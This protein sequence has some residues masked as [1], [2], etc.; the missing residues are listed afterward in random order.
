VPTSPALTGVGSP[1]LAPTSVPLSQ[2]QAERAKA[3]RRPVIHKLALGPASEA[4]LLNDKPDGLTEQEFKSALDKV[5]DLENGK[6]VLK[7]KAFKELD[8]FSYRA[9]S[10]ADRQAAIENA[11]RAYDKLRLNAAEPEWEKLLPPEERGTGKC[12]SKLQAK[13]AGG[14]IQLVKA[15]KINVHRAE[16]SGRDTP[17]NTEGDNVS[18]D[19]PSSTS[20]KGSESMTRSYSNPGATKSRRVSEKE[21]QTKR[22]LAKPGSK[23]AKSAGTK[24]S[25]KKLLGKESTKIKSSEFV[26]GSDDEDDNNIIPSLAA[27]V[28]PL[29]AKPTSKPAVKRAREDASDQTL[30]PVTKK[31]RASSNTSPQKPS[32]LASSP[33]TNVSDVDESSSSN[34]GSLKRKAG[35]SISSDGPITKRHQVSS[36]SSDEAVSKRHQKSVSSSSS[37]SVSSTQG[38]HQSRSGNGNGGSTIRTNVKEKYAHIPQAQRALKAHKFNAFYKSYKQLHS[39][40]SKTKTKDRLKM[41]ELFEMQDRLT[42][43]KKEVLKG[44]DDADEVE[45]GSGLGKER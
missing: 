17:I 39:E 37:S 18:G 2:Q 31:S 19:K 11:I 44:L 32:P 28:K 27:V 30:A 16:E 7:S 20:V 22:L 38:A 12:L 6:W 42:K 10:T 21:A 5:A 26:S 15:P 35:S 33:P 41:A 9:Y 34:N 8:V 43:L 29:V 23:I 4:E 40:L 24:P 36:I 14:A 13:I 45:L 25:E 3:T 1:S